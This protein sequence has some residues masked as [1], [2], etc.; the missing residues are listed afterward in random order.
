MGV[1]IKYDLIYDAPKSRF[2]EENA[3]LFAQRPFYSTPD[4]DDEIISASLRYKGNKRKKKSG[5][6]PR[7][8]FN[9][10]CWKRPIAK[11]L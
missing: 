7:R 1:E 2:N 9:Y 3:S 11:T 8:S 4:N 6:V 10:Y 5:K